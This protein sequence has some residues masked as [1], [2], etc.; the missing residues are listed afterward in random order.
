[1]N[2][3][4]AAYRV[5]A[6]KLYWRCDP[7]IFQCETSKDA[8]ALEGIIG[9]RRALEAIKLGLEIE[10]PGY[11]IFVTGLTGTGRT[12][13]IKTLLEQL[14]KPLEIPGDKC[15]VNNFKNPD[16][17]LAIELP[18]GKGTRFRK[19]MEDLVNTLIQQ[20]PRIF[21][22]DDYRKRTDEI[23]S[24]HRAKQKELIDE[25]NARL[26]KEGF[27]L[28]QIQV[29]PFTQPAVAPVADGQPVP[30][31]KLEEMAKQGLFPSERLE[32]LQERQPRLTSELETALRKTREIEK[33]IR[34]DIELLEQ[35]FGRPLVSGLISDIKMHYPDERINRYMDDVQQDILGNLKRFKE[36]EESSE[37]VERASPYPFTLQED[38]FLPYHVNIMVDNSGLDRRPVVIETTPSYRNLFGTIERTM[39]RL[40]IGR[41]DFTHIKPGSI[42][43][44]DG[45]FLI[46]NALDA[47]TEPMV[48]KSLKRTLKNSQL[49]MG[50]WDPMGLFSMVSGLK[51][52]PFRIK[53]KVIMVGDTEIY[54]IL[55]NLD[56]DF[57][58]IFKVKADFDT[59]MNR[60]EESI[61]QYAS[62]IRKICETEG[63][64]HFD[65]SAMA[66]LVEYGVRL[67]GRQVKVSTRF[68][69]IADILRESSYWARKEGSQFVTASHVQRCIEQRRDRV[70][71]V[72]EKIQELITTGTIMVDVEGERA[73]QV[74]G[75]AVYDMGDYMFGKPSRIT[76]KTSLGRAGIIN[77][78]REA[79]LSGKTHDKGV[80]ILEG[81][82]RGKYAQD[83]PMTLSASICFEQSYSGVE[84][85]SASSTELY[86][87]LSSLS[88]L[89]IKQS[90]AVTG[91][92]NQNGEI[93]AI[94]GVNQ[95]IEGFFDCCRARG[96]NGDQGVII[97]AANV[98]DLM[99]RQ[100]VKTAVEEGKFTIYAARNIDE[101][102]EILTGHPAGERDV[103]NKF[104]EDSVNGLV[105][106]KLREMA[107][108]MK[109]FEAE[110]EKR[111]TGG[112]D[113]EEEP[114]PLNGSEILPT[115]GVK[116]SR[117]GGQRWP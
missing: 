59:V 68:S 14:N 12:T 114:S 42:L 58:K 111:E 21:Q 110:E 49:E 104:P 75:L 113:A 74:N 5:P 47:L 112:D 70:N 106:R 63:L 79:K 30:M 97:P 23:V 24:R 107:E 65:R 45:G 46:L 105:D 18:A 4:I 103:S 86:A 28:V 26:H 64:C 48:W 53:L 9:Q 99:L 17:P 94:G 88:G 95:K 54:H 55:Y 33:L 82:L 115:S 117:I 100:D 39:D 67:A 40:G 96:L 31:E 71:L 38:P 11:N 1:M 16:V 51:P 19:D 80:L 90:I 27:T 57:R 85:D 29:G 36:K 13:T 20:I 6:E 50:G 52:E 109:G 41:T 89:P 72:E 35:E 101:G 34:K 61:C 87:L 44:A 102:I 60:D 98:V 3:K 84:G 73:G 8:L 10:S 93:Q 69:D 76:A 22:S 15:Y 77:I 78:E 37:S 83:K 7:N 32:Q 108:A 25:L 56:E 116:P 91:S 92:V 62:F 66:A 2:E 81:Y 43:I